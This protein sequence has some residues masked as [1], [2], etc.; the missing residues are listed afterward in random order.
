MSCTVTSSP[1]TKIYLYNQAWI[2]RVVGPVSTEEGYREAVGR[3]PIR[4]PH[5]V[6]LWL[7]SVVL[8]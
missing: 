6:W 1:P 5:G 2:D 7:L 3:E 8:R 4:Q